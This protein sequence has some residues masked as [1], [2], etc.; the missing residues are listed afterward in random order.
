MNRLCHCKNNWFKSWRVEYQPFLKGVRVR[1]VC[2][3]FPDLAFV[4]TYPVDPAYESAT[5]WIGSPEWKFLKTLWIWNCV[6]AKSGYA[7]VSCTVNIVFKM[8]TS[9]HA[10]FPILPEESWVTEIIRIFVGY[11]WTG[12]FDL[13]ADT[14]GKTKGRKKWEIQLGSELAL[15]LSFLL[16][17]AS[18]ILSSCFH[19]SWVDHVV[20]EGHNYHS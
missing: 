9:T 20:Y 12:K 16:S 18:N 11:V 5:F 4:H 17:I 7:K 2:D 14:C 10:Q 15:F 13:N 8:T 6:D 1:L 19:F 3:S